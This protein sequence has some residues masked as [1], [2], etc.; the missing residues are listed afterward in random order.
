MHRSGTSLVA[1]IFFEAGANMGG[2]GT[3][4]KTDR[5]NPEG[6]YE[7]SDLRFLNIDL[8]HGPWGRWAYFKL[9]GQALILKRAARRRKDLEIM[10]Q[11]YAA[12]LVKDPRFCLTLPAWLEHGAKVTDLLICLREPV[13]VARSLQIRNK[14]PLSLGLKIWK[15]HFKRLMEILAEN[16]DIRARF[17]RY[18]YLMDPVKRLQE[19]QNAF[20][21]MGFAHSPE[22]IQKLSASCIKDGLYHHQNA[23]YKYAVDVRELWEEL[24]R[25][26]ALMA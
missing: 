4:Y 22:E 15:V 16:K 10:A 23:D 5:W 19:L 8:L 24:K 17:I 2:A 20:C 14:I 21:A 3:F 9:P 11:K 1:K 18:D 25:R 26:H 12:M 6:Y 7:Q 13:Q